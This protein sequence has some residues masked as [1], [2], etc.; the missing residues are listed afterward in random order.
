MALSL[1]DVKR[2]SSCHKTW[3]DIAAIA[4]RLGKGSS[5][6]DTELNHCTVMV[7]T[8]LTLS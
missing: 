6:S 1:D 3:D 2:I 4:D 5:V 7:D 8:T